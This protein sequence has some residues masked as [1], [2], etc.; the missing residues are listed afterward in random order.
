MPDD[1]AD[2]VPG[3]YE[4][5][6]RA[7]VPPL[8]AAAQ[9]LIREVSLHDGLLRTLARDSKRLE[10]MFRAGDQQTGYFDARLAYAHVEL[11]SKDEEFLRTVVGSRD[12]ELLY[13]EFDSA[14]DG[15]RWI[16]RLLFWPYQEVSIEFA[17]L[18]LEVTAASRRFD[19]GGDGT[20]CEQMR[21]QIQHA[22]EMHPDLSDCPDS[23]IVRLGD[24]GQFGLRVHD[25]GGSS[26]RIRYC[27]W[28]GTDLWS[29]T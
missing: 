7:L 13:D 10:L 18:N 29:S 16:H 4:A 15:E 3:A 22:C 1:E 25:G 24:P 21:R 23:L 27:P 2:H 5:H 9:R 6:I 19:Q 17:A 28:C 12:V 20:C 14:A 8:P 26:I 11:S